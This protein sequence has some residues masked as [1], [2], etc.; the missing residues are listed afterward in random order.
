M[1]GC[2]S[3]IIK[4]VECQ[5]IGAF[6]LWC[7]RR[8]LRVPWTAR[9][10]NPSILKEIVLNSWKTWCWNGNSN[11]L[12]TWCEDPDAGKDWGQEEKGVAERRGWQRMRWLD[13]IA[14]SMDTSVSKLW[15]QWRTGKP[16]VLQFMGSQRVRHG[17]ETENNNSEYTHTH[18]HTHSIRFIWRSTHSPG[19]W[20]VSSLRALEVNGLR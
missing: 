19:G 18:T 17:L 7:W 20:A 10:F 12:A 6:E 4:K 14:G 16:G 5:R 8:L 1:Y 2:E 9:R 3:W 13:G 11:T 15:G